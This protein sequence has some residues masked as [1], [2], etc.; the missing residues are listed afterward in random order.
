MKF[1]FNSALDR[2]IA[3][4]NLNGRRFQVPRMLDNRYKIRDILAAGGM[5]VIFIANDTQLHNKKVLIKR[6]LYEPVL[7]EHKNDKHRL[8]EIP[9]RRKALDREFGAMR[10]GWARGIPNIPVPLD[11]IT[12]I[13]PDLFGPHTD[14]AG[15]SFYAEPELYTKESYLV[16]NYFSGGPVKPEHPQIKS[17]PL[18]FAQFYIRS[19]ANV[20]SR[21]HQPYKSG[22]RLFEFFYCDLKPDNVLLTQDKRIV[23]ID[24]GSFAI[25]VDGRLVG[26]ITTTP[27][28]CAPELRHDQAMFLSPAV[29]VYTLAVSVFELI[30]GVPPGVDSFGNTRLDWYSFE[31]LAQKESKEFWIPVFKTA[32][33]KDP[34]RRYSTMQEFSFALTQRKVKK[35][36]RPAYAYSRKTP[37]KPYR[38]SPDWTADPKNIRDLEAS[39]QPIFNIPASKQ[40]NFFNIP[41]WSTFVH[42]G[43]EPDPMT[44][45]LR[46]SLLD[47]AVR[48]LTMNLTF[49]PEL[50]ETVRDNRHILH[51][52]GFIEGR[53]SRQES[54]IIQSGL[55]KTLY[56]FL[57]LDKLNF[58]M[59]GISEQ[60]L[61]T[62]TLGNP[63]IFEYWL[64][65]SENMFPFG[66]N[67]L[68]SRVVGSRVI[69]P[70]EVV[71]HQ[72]WEKEKSL[73]YLAGIHVLLS[74]KPAHTYDLYSQ[75]CLTRKTDYENLVRNMTVSSKLKDVLLGLLNPLPRMRLSLAEALSVLK[76]RPLKKAPRPAAGRGGIQIQFTQALRGFKIEFR[77]LGK[78]VNKTSGK[79]LI[80]KHIILHNAPP[81]NYEK[82]LKQMG[83]QWQ[84]SGKNE[85]QEKII[86]NLLDNAVAEKATH[87]AV[88]ICDN[89]IKSLSLLDRLKEFKQVILFS[90]VNPFESLAHVTYYP[91]DQFMIKKPKRK[92]GKS[93]KRP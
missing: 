90:P 77:E 25:K 46:D 73:A 3:V 50:I 70:P 19:I 59:I 66:L 30:T 54:W 57:S 22:G 6:C 42:D 9:F 74:I 93:P 8:N 31:T 89:T 83:I 7:F 29:D 45:Q 71:E 24:M 32:L 87:L 35:K 51:M 85:S 64:L 91:I 27:G 11:L 40:E 75:K 1:S 52:P 81:E 17:N 65:L 2:E 16:I 18:G 47:N 14:Q 41:A 13:N 69:I 37:D 39:G 80:K 68:I 36:G 67:P 34:D 23:L 21:F 20:L 76:D 61:L 33:D 72:A 15:N 63:F 62:D 44:A 78:I 43:L 56:L 53:N 92:Y 48:H 60:T 26:G 4:L 28:Y 12:D 10:H 88:L 55:E 49:C 38:L 79:A 82:T 5:G 58:R 86:Y 84:A